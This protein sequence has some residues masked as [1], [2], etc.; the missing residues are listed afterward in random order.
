VIRRVLAQTRIE[1]LLTI[2]RGESLLVTVAI[3]AGILVFFTAIDILP[4][5]TRRVVDFLV[6]GVL[7]LAV[8]SSGMVSLGIATAFERQSGVL[9]RLGVTPLGRPGLLVAKAAA[10]LFVIALQVAVIV[11]LGLALGWEPDGSA[12]EG[13]AVLVLGAV[14][15]AGLGFTMAGT[16]RAETTLAVA[17]GAFL[18]LLLLGGIVVPASRLPGTLRNVAEVLPAEPFAHA[19]R[20]AL[21]AEPFGTRPIT[22]LA[23]WALG[24]TLLAVTRFRWD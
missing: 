16:L 3:P 7:A 6:P 2:R 1:L 22:T 18:V 11:L 20:A 21:G 14:A 19:L 9:R 17:N 15:F 10:T 4:H 12:L 5:D 23:V 24:A 13:A 8:I